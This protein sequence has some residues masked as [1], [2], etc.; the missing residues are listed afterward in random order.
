MPGATHTQFSRGKRIRI[1]FRDGTTW[2]RKFIHR[3]ARE[4]EVADDAGTHT[5]IRIRQIKSVTIY[6]AGDVSPTP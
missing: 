3:H 6:K 5:H 1:V 4:L 2:V